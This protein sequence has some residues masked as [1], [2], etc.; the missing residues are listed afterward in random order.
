MK[1]ARGTRS[2]MADLRGDGPVHDGAVSSDTPAQNARDRP[3]NPTPVDCVECPPV[4]APA[5]RG[6]CGGDA[7]S[8]A[9]A[10]ARLA[11]GAERLGGGGAGREQVP[12]LASRPGTLAV[13]GEL[14]A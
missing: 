13:E 12:D 6:K 2:V 9:D 5:S 14:H 7:A 11:H 10:A 1:R 8:A 3:R 4:A